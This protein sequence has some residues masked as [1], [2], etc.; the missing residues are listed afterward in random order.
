M[1]PTFL[2]RVRSRMAWFMVRVHRRVHSSDIG[3]NGT[4][5][6]LESEATAMIGKF[7]DLD[8]VWGHDH[9]NGGKSCRVRD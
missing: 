7:G 6:R 4:V 2:E 5:F 1:N 8:V 9:A 3:E